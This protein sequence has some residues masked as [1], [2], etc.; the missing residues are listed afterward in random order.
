[1]DHSDALRLKTT[2]KYLLN[3]L[4]PEQLDQFE[5]HMFDCPECAVDV[6]AAAMFVEQSKAVLSEAR[7]PVPVQVVPATH[8]GWLNWLR[9]AFAAPAFALLLLVVGYQNLVT[10]PKLHQALGRPQ[11]LPWAAV[12]I[13]TYGAGDAGTE[14]PVIPGRGFLLLVRIPPEGAFTQYSA[15]L[16]NPSGQREFSLRIPV[17]SDRDQKQDRWAIQVPG[18]RWT[19][20]TYTLKI[21]GTTSMGEAREVGQTSF[22][23]KIQQ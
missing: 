10:Y 18:A 14:I 12:N 4:D 20:G 19:P 22:D 13:G 11:S 16:L 9:P 2:E 23:L 1:M 6:R 17:P 8:S 21:R 3:E 5:E 7:G 15:D